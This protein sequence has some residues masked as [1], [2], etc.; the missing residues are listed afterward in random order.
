[1]RQ[2]AIW[3]NGVVGIAGRVSRHRS[4]SPRSWFAAPPHVNG[5]ANRNTANKNWQTPPNTGRFDETARVSGAMRMPITGG[6]TDKRKPESEDCNRERQQVRDQAKHLRNLANN[7][8]ALDLR[9]FCCKHLAFEP[10]NRP[11]CKQDLS[12]DASL[13]Y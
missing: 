3:T 1:V 7:T 2:R 8:S 10:R 13:D 4:F 11:S 12:F 9:A 6:N 5:N